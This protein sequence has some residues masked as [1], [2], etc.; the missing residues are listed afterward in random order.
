MGIDKKAVIERDRRIAKRKAD[1]PGLRFYTAETLNKINMFLDQWGDG[2]RTVTIIAQFMQKH[3]CHK[4]QAYRYMKLAQKEMQIQTNRTQAQRVAGSIH[5]MDT[6]YKKAIEK[7]KLREAIQATEHKDKLLAQVDGVETGP[8]T[9]MEILIALI[10]G[11]GIGAG[12][13]LADAI[14]KRVDSGLQAKTG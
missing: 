8:K 5:R 3:E 11:R 10:D 14:V 9:K 6:I 1:N 13:V 4:S 7:G 12:Q 2:V